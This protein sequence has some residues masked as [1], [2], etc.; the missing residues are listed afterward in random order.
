MPFWTYFFLLFLKSLNTVLSLKMTKS[1]FWFLYDWHHFNLASI[2]SAVRF[3]ILFIGS[4]CSYFFKY[5]VSVLWLTSIPCS[6]SSSL[7]SETSKS[8]S[9]ERIW[10]I[11]IS[12]SFVNRDFLPDSILRIII[13]FVLSFSTLL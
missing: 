6:Q 9:S 10:L 1:Q 2:W 7:I 11:F 13:P 8:L 4:L 5:L 12:R 3:I